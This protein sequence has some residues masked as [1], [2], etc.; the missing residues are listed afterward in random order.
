VT[1]ECTQ[2]PYG[3]QD[4]P[5]KIAMYSPDREILW[6]GA[7]IQG[8]SHRDGAG[9]LLGL[10]I[11]ERAP[12][13]ISIPA[14]PSGDNFREL[15]D[16]NQAN[17]SAVIGEL[18]GNATLAGLPTPST[19][20][21]DLHSFASEEEFALS[22]GISGRYLLFSGSASGDFSRNAAETTVIAHFVQKMYE[23]VVEPPQTPDA[24]FSADF[25]EDTLDEQIALGRIGPDNVPVYVS[26]I[27]YGRMMTFAFTSTASEQEIRGTIEAAYETLGNG[28]SV[29]LSAKQK[30]ILNEAKIAVS[31]LGGDAEASLALIR[32]GSWQEYFTEDAALSSAAPLSYTFRHL[33]DGSI[34]RVTE[35]TEY[36]V[37][38]CTPVETSSG[39]CM[40]DADCPPQ[41]F[42]VDGE[43]RA[44][45]EGPPGDPTCS[46]GVDN[47]GD[48]LIDTNDPDCGD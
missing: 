46:D 19:I 28:V 43:C 48:G 21:F 26:N 40:F 22:L 44:G 17:A 32:S 34:A 23:V 25:T 1:F 31:S 47:D 15:Q 30:T 12:I 33:G 4:T 10:P 13:R 2:T 9:S 5:D 45:T 24:F 35:A 42:C 36:M 14:L 7:L 11:A 38:E 3:M 29:E 27:V 41:E 39:T 8:K 18:I 37:K 20:S 6:P 16:P